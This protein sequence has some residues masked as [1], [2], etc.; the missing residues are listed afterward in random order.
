[1]K[2]SV[3][4]FGLS[5]VLLFALSL[6]GGHVS[7][8]DTA[9]KLTQE[10]FTR[11]TQRLQLPF[12]INEGQTDT[13]ISFY[14]HTFG[15]TVFVT[16]TGEIIYS[17][18]QSGGRE[19]DGMKRIERASYPARYINHYARCRL[20]EYQNTL[21]S[22]SPVLM[23]VDTSL[24]NTSCKKGLILKE[25]LVDGRI[26][27]IRGEDESE[28]KVSY[29]K[30]ND[31]SKWRSGIATY[32]EVNLG[33][34]YEGIE[35]RL[36]AYGDNVEKLFC[37]KPG[38]DPRQ[39]QVRLSGVKLPNPPNP[40]L[41]KGGFTVPSSQREYKGHSPLLQEVDQGNFPPFLKGD[42][43]GLYI[44][45]HGELEVETELGKV[46]FT[47]PVAFQEIGGKMV[48]V[49][50]EYSVQETEA[51]SQHKEEK[52]S[53]LTT[54]DPSTSH[55]VYGFTVASYDTSKDLIIDPLLAS[56]FLG[57]SGSDY[58]YSLAIDTGGNVY[59]TGYTLDATTD[60]PTTGS[61]YDT[62][63]NG[64]FDA[65]VSKFNSGLTSLLASTFLGGASD[66]Y[67][68]SLAIDMEG[69][70]YV[71]GYTFDATTDLPI[72]PGAYDPSHN[73]FSDVFV[74]KFNSGLTS[75]LASTFLG[76]ASDDYGYSLAIDTEGNVYVTGRTNDAA[77]DLPTTSGAYDPSHNGFS[78][79][80]VSKF[81]SGL[82]S[83]LASTFLGGAGTDYGSSLAIDTVGKVY[84]A[85]YT[86]DAATDLPTTSG[87]YDTSHNGG[88][89][90]FVSKF[91][92]GLTSLLASTFL[93]GATTDYGNSLAIDT[94]GNVY[95]IG[96]TSDATTYLP[97]T[98]GAYD[99]S[100]NG[101]FDAFV[102]KFNSGLT[103]LLASTFLGGATTDYGNSLAIDTEG[104]VYVT[105]STANAATD[106]PT[107]GGAYDTSHNGGYDTFVSKFN[108]GLTNLLASTF[109]GGATTDYG[110]SLTID[111]GET[112]M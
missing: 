58:G 96:D 56:T 61:T 107:T 43:G 42:Q 41:E 95:V 97:T 9:R 76:G 38:A 69:D 22:V 85:G 68:Y 34:V 7:G 10:E 26:M 102:S 74:S 71:T 55:L 14:A 63:H 66:D 77:T 5:V 47:K 28:T 59:V 31:P 82:T 73:G 25:E 60:L 80:F 64:G 104:N 49:A 4:F 94:E 21:H 30:G 98:S 91:N 24:Q 108:S 88:Y 1:M 15:G 83:L 72:T 109:L 100:H 13:R 53:Q 93:G 78:D 90:A 46:S 81:N 45:D 17:L 106:L 8:E 51:R 32:G 11:K 52:T 35:L 16:K 2:R 57:G 19:D 105:G 86:H 27:G 101:G 103:N 99:P 39:I 110:N 75:L 54:P 29:F 36:K 50:V 112:S 40:P 84:V 20:P 44:N 92:S 33:E 70:I 67:G 37:V 79:V 62:S 111:T 23:S 48:D 3:K 65:F 87:A 12:I 18:P 6:T 89:D